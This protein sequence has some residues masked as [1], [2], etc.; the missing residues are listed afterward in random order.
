MSLRLRNLWRERYNSNTK[1]WKS[2]LWEVTRLEDTTVERGLGTQPDTKICTGGLPCL[3]LNKEWKKVMRESHLIVGKHMGQCP[4]VQGVPGTWESLT[5][6]KGEDLKP[7]SSNHTSSGVVTTN[8]DVP[9]QGRQADQAPGIQAD[10]IPG[11]QADQ[12]SSLW[13]NL[14]SGHNTCLPLLHTCQ[15]SVAQQEQDQEL[16]STRGHPG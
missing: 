8:R 7:L 3:K 11:H 13:A 16:K 9:F 6:G 12:I 4:K 14:P 10:Q 2:E 5:V 1:W 15:P